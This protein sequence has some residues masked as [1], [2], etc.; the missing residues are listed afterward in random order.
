MLEGVGRKLGGWVQKMLW[1]VLFPKESSEL[2]IFGVEA[3]DFKLSD[4]SI[5][6]GIS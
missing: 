2:F 6:Y 3:C 1:Y 4:G 5:V